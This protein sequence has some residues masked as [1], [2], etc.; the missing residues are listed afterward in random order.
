MPDYVYAL[1]DFT[2]ENDDEIPFKA[3]ERIEV[4]ERDDAYGDGWWQVSIKFRLPLVFC[5]VPH[6]QKLILLF[7][8]SEPRWKNRSFPSKLYCT[9]TGY[10][11]NR[12][13]FC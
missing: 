11:W 13:F 6:V 4:L 9:R 1:H 5:F 2:P 8:G 3:G 12:S 10:Q 7:K